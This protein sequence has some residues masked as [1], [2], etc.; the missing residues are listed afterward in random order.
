MRI[1]ELGWVS[2]VP[3]DVVRLNGRRVRRL[4]PPETATVDRKVVGDSFSPIYKDA[5]L[6][7]RFR[8]V[9]WIVPGRR[10]LRPLSRATSI[11]R[12]NARLQPVTLI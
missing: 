1:A 4:R 9:R 3:I 6:S 11:G 7:P 12:S 2:S 5:H 8:G 10:T